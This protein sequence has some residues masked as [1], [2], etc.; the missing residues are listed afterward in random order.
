VRIGIIAGNLIFL[1]ATIGGIFFARRNTK[2]GRGDRRG[3]MRLAIFIL[4][5]SALP[6]IL[7][8]PDVS[9]LSLFLSPYY[10][11]LIWILYMAV[12]PFVRRRWPR[13]LV[14]WTRL[15]SG[16]WRDPLVARD[17]FVGFA[18][19]ALVSCIIYIVAAIPSRIYLAGFN[20]LPE[21][22]LDSI[23][24]ARFTAANCLEGLSEPII[25][26]LIFICLLVVMRPLLR[27]QWAA[28]IA[29]VVISAMVYT[30]GPI[31]GLISTASF[32]FLAMRFGLIAGIAYWFA[33]NSILAQLS[34]LRLKNS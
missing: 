9:F 13:D 27:N 14:S 11:V 6:W 15:L 32:M 30:F 10:A 12:E 3:A 23:L 24:G 16:E 4:A 25:V 7:R 26:G 18:F 5:L 20:Y 19:G 21:L 28:V 33:L 34:Q 31:A 1:S 22:A 29:I 17:M 2:L 8:L